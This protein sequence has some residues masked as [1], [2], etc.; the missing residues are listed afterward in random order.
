M[1]EIPDEENSLEFESDNFYLKTEEEMRL[2]FPY[3]PEAIENT[4]KIADMCNF[5]FE[6][7]NTKLPNFKVPDGQSHYD[8]FR[9]KCYEGLKIR[10]GNNPKQEYVDRLEYELSVINDM[11]YVDYFLIVADFIQYA[12]DN[13]IPV[14]PGRGSGAG[15][16]CAYC[17]GITNIDPI[18]YNLIFERFLNPERVSMPDIDVDFCYER[19]QE[20]IDYVIDKYGADHVSQIVTFGTMKARAA[21]RDVGRAM[22]LSYATVDNVAKKIPRVLGITIE[23]ALKDSEEL[24]ALYNS[25]AKSFKD[26]LFTSIKFISELFN[27]MLLLAFFMNVLHPFSYADCIN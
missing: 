13:G 10:Y 5:D 7:G 16:I 17:M 6:F 3:V 4:Q 19:R 11:G 22:G 8:Y 26:L 9:A 14:G 12:R 24:K 2:L 27:F 20:V 23:D 18:K 1:E 25:D 21:L 15:S